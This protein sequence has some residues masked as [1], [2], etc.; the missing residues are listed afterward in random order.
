MKKEEK[1]REAGK[2]QIFVRSYR[3]Q[4]F[5]FSSGSVNKSHG[6]RKR[7]RKGNGSSLS[8]TR[9]W[10][11]VPIAESNKRKLSRIARE[12]RVIRLLSIRLDLLAA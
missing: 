11:L 1:E 8:T 7:K 3:E 6:K 9:K 2:V 10:N 5:L 12:K 4:G